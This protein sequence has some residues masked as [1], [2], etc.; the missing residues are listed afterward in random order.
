MQYYWIWVTYPDG[1]RELCRLTINE[2]DQMRDLG[3]H[4]EFADD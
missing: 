3:Y 1:H 2:A 4:V